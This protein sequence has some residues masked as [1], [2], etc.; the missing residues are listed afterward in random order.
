MNRKGNVQPENHKE[1]DQVS[2][3]TQGII[4][5]MGEE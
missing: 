5:A 2:G 1:S 3:R 4:G